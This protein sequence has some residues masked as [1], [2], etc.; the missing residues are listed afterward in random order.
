MK[1]SKEKIRSQ[2]KSKRVHL[3]V[4]EGSINHQRVTVMRGIPIKL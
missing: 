3:E 2:D 4:R 1:N